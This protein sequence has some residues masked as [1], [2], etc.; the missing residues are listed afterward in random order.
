MSDLPLERL[1]VDAPFSYVGLDVFGPWEVITSCT[2]S[3]QSRDKRWAVL[4]TCM[5]TR[6]IHIEVI[7]TMTSSSFINALRKFFLQVRP[8]KLTH[9]VLITF[10]AEVS[11]IVNARP[12]IPVSTNPEAPLIHRKWAYLFLQSV[13]SQKEICSRISG[14]EFKFWQRHS[15]LGGGKNIWAHFR[16]GPNPWQP[17]AAVLHTSLRFH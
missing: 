7:E 13:S 12:L 17:R 16:V 14:R 9:E 11:A 1:Q 15:G 2:R 3:G 4:F 5:S 8:L 10:M 6:A